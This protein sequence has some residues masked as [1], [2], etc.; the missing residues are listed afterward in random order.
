MLRHIVMWKLKG[1]IV[2]RKENSQKIS[3][4]LNGLKGKVPSIKELTISINSNKAPI[5]N[6]D[7]MLDTTFESF[8]ALGEYQIHPLHKEVA[9]VISNLREAR[10]CIDFEF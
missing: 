4:L 7:V 5:D 9:T 10:S 1:S 6:W 3:D 8:E 2:E